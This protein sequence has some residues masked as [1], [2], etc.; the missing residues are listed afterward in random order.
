MLYVFILS[1]LLAGLWISPLA[2]SPAE[3]TRVLIL[4]PQNETLPASVEAGTAIRTRLAERYGGNLDIHTEYLEL[5]RYQETHQRRLAADYLA[6]KYA[7]VGL[8]LIVTIGSDAL[9]FV[10][11][12]RYAF[13]SSTPIVFCCTSLDSVTAL[14][15][16]SNVFGIVSD[17]DVG[18]TAALALRLQPT[19]RRLIVIT[20]AS[21]LDR[22]FE[23]GARDALRAFD[24]RLSIEYLSGLPRDELLKAVSSVPRDTIILMLTYFMDRNGWQSVPRDVAEEVAKA[25]SAPT[26]AMFDTMLGGGIVG[27]HMDAF[28][29]VGI[30]TADLAI[31]VLAG[32]VA[33]GDAIRLR[34][35]HS[36]LVD[37]RQLERWN[38]PRNRLPPE[39]TVL[40]D[41]P[42]VWETHRKETTATLAAFGI[43]TLALAILLAQVRRR[44]RAETHLRESDERLNF[45]AASSG[46]GLWQYDIRTGELWASEHCRAIFGLSRDCQLTPDTLLRRVHPE[47]RSIAAAAIRAA[48]YGPHTDNLLE[49]CAIRPD[50]KI[51]S[52]QARG[53]STLDDKGNTTSISGIFRDLTPYRAAQKEARELSQR[54]LAIQDEE[55]QRIAQEL[56]DSTAQHLAAINLN[57]M[58]LRGSRH[59]AEPS[60]PVFKDIQDS[61]VSAMNEMR[62][63]TYLL[64]PQELV[65]GELREA[66]TKYIEGFS[67]RTGLHVTLRA[68]SELDGFAQDLQH[69]LLRIV[70]ESL[71]NVHRHASASQVTVKLQRRAGWIHL[72][73][74]DDG[75]GLQY[76]PRE[77]D[78]ENSVLPSGVGIPGMTA[79]AQQ[80]GGRL[81]VRSRSS[82]TIVHA[83]LPIQFKSLTAPAN[84]NGTGTLTASER[85]REDTISIHAKRIENAGPRLSRRPTHVR[86]RH[87]Q[88]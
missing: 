49:F 84:K 88:A 1:S 68:S 22:R 82:G 81:V 28:G 65:H 78:K 11:R 76:L 16:P 31:Q 70:Q 12:H 72:L 39:A 20:G 48:T 43:V 7:T 24:S 9:G 83:S 80:L 17:Y 3:K 47:D 27:G 69:S 63:F 51:C 41:K 44:I 85:R 30:A 55:R 25:A 62:T 71:A 74:A 64:Y 2:A 59:S 67:Q 50:G 58:A 13:D 52:I 23:V 26:Y 10:L 21:E 32:A 73:I 57:L 53:H 46:I 15:P 34:S 33:I 14:A 38:L 75:V 61:L 29:R 45:A 35:A 5:S 42:A 86:E 8:S 56:H 36:I 79:R 87:H 4:H 18:K 6:A 77:H 19:A 66:L 37:A 40:F 54:I 60:A